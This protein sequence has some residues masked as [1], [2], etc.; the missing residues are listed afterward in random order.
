MVFGAVFPYPPRKR[1]ECPLKQISA[2]KTISFFWVLAPILQSAENSGLTWRVVMLELCM[3]EGSTLL[4]NGTKSIL[5]KNVW[6]MFACL[7][8]FFLLDLLFECC[9]QKY[10]WSKTQWSRN[11]KFV[12]GGWMF[13]DLDPQW[14]HLVASLIGYTKPKVMNTPHQTPQGY[15]IYWSVVSPWVV[16]SI[17][18]WRTRGIGS[19]R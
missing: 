1:N 14:H 11:I 17:P 5:E 13:N 9:Q 2:W 3:A 16:S 8:D 12:V 7:E 18:I 10:G 15:D 6:R 4:K 19:V